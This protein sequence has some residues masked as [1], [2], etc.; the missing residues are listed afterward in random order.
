LQLSSALLVWL[1]VAPSQAERGVDDLIA[2]TPGMVSPPTVAGRTTIN[3]VPVVQRTVTSSARIDDLKAYF[4]QAYKKAGLFIG[5]AQESF[6]PEKG[7]QVTGLDTENLIAYMALFQPA[8]KFTSVVVAAASMGSQD[9]GKGTEAVGPV[10]PGGHGM[11]SYRVE[12]VQGMTYLCTGTPAEI[13]KFYREELAKLGYSETDELIF[14]KGNVRAW[15]TVSPGVSERSVALYIQ[16]TPTAA[17]LKKKMESMQAMPGPAA[18]TPPA[19][20][21]PAKP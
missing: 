4:T 16:T 1:A 7:Q 21:K 20:T 17:D 12:M 18:P 3:A 14:T 5:P 9:V 15:V 19:P 10:F 6:Q 2:K 8:G 13:K 11:T